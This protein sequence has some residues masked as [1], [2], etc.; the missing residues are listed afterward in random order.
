MQINVRRI[1]LIDTELFADELNNNDVNSADLNIAFGDVNAITALSD[2]VSDKANWIASSSCLGAMSHLGTDLGDSYVHVMSL[3]NTQ[4]AI[5]V[6]SCDISNGNATE[7][8]SSTI[9]TAMQRANR[10]G[11]MPSLVWIIQAPGQEEAVLDGVQTVLGNSVPI[12]G[13]SSADNAIEGKWVQ[14]DGEHLYSNGLVIAAMYTEEPVSCYFSSGYTSTQTQAEVTAVE[15]RVIYTLDNKPAGEVY[16]HWLQK[17]GHPPL[18]P[19]SI[20]SDS[21]YFPLGR[22]KGCKSDPIPL[23]SHPSKL[24]DDNSLELFATVKQ[25]DILTLMQGEQ[26]NLI[27]RAAE[28]TEVVLRTHEL[29]Y[30]TRPKGVL[31]VFC[32]GCMLAVKD[33]LETIHASI[34]NKAQGLPFL[35]AFTFGEQG[36]FPDGKSRH[37]N[38]MISATVF[39]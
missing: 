15:G 10:L 35:V 32:G 24:N 16:N 29:N 37:G 3:Q 27:S 18:K 2:A 11:E 14:F 6:A 5:G 31:L 34:L 17:Y 25:G 12:F 1:G 4:G 26:H 33:Q 20:L 28:V 9:V 19:G 38:L 23:L 7:L 36:C 8:A 13:G 39:G 30:E 21:T 22:H